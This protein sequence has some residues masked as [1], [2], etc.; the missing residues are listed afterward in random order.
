M[1]EAEWLSC[2]DPPMMLSFL[3]ESGRA[4]DRKLRLFAVACCRRVWHLLT[5]ERSRSAVG[6]A[7]R[8]A[9]GLAGR[10]E[11]AR[12]EKGAEV[13]A[14]AEASER[15]R[16][17]VVPNAPHVTQAALAAAGERADATRWAAWATSE[18]APVPEEERRCHCALL[19]DIFG[20]LTFRPVTIFPSVR[21]WND[22]VV[23]RMAQAIYDE[24]LL[25]SGHLAQDRL[26]VLGDALEDAGCQDTEL[27]Q[28]LRGP[29][30]HVRGCFVVDLLL[31]RG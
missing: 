10:E 27:L 17:G 30:P 4:S 31:S 2:A 9:D 25:P 18:A 26:A 29:G 24:R 15:A 21:T 23:V 7:E 13:P 8:Y 1:T 16:E 19:R 28:H 14:F 12:A 11:L 3:R 5:D 6:M 22:G 20:P